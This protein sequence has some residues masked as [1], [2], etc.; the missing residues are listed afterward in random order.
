M[1]ERGFFIHAILYRFG[2]GTVTKTVTK[3]SW[4]NGCTWAFPFSIENLKDR[5]MRTPGKEHSFFQ[6]PSGKLHSFL[7][8]L[9][10]ILQKQSFPEVPMLFRKSVLAFFVLPIYF[11]KMGIRDLIKG[12]TMISNAKYGNV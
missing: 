10:P 9:D 2:Y 8:K 7:K 4:E 11:L 6:H 1:K 12:Y 5:E 3:I